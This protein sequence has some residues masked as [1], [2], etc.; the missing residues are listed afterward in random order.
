MK[1]VLFG[2]WLSVWLLSGCQ[3]QVSTPIIISYKT[4]APTATRPLPLPPLSTATPAPTLLLPT[5]TSHLGCQEQHGSIS[6]FQVLEKGFAKAM[7]VNIYLPPCYSESYPHGYPVLYLIHGQSFSDDQWIRL[8]VPETADA[9]FI[10]GQLKPFIVVMPRDEYYLEPWFQSSFGDNLVKGLVP[11]VDS[12]YHTCTQ[13]SCRAIGGLSRGATWAVVLGM[14]YWQEFGT[15]GAHSLPDSPY[16]EATT[17]DHFKVMADQGYPRL[18][19]DVGDLDGYR[20]GTLKFVAYLEKYHIPF[21]WHLNQ[22]NHDE[23]YWHAHVPEYV[24]WYGQAW[25]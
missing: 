17:R 15:I 5:P 8:G 13:R 2:L 7:D 23:V 25:K 18:S 21:T 19:V 9:Y 6:N 10:S 24:L 3:S 16:T 4:P 11:W 20:S 12:H 1:Q 14:T 22:G